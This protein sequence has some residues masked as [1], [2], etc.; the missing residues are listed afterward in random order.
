[1]FNQAATQKSLEAAN[2]KTLS[3]DEKKTSLG[4][5]S[6]FI[7][8]GRCRANQKEIS[9]RLLRSPQNVKSDVGNLEMKLILARNRHGD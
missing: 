2:Y 5:G 4:E 9:A 1:M 7:S 8:S 3:G 6:V